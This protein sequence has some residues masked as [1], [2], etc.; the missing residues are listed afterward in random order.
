MTA[1]VPAPPYHS[2]SPLPEPKPV[3][4]P[5]PVP[6]KVVVTAP[7]PPV[8]SILGKVVEVDL[9]NSTGEHRL[10]ISNKSTANV[11][12]EIEKHEQEEEAAAAAATAE[13]KEDDNDDNGM[14]IDTGSEKGVEKVCEPEPNPPDQPITVDV[15]IATDEVLIKEEAKSPVGDT[16]ESESS[17][18]IVPHQPT[19]KMQSSPVKRKK[20]PLPLLSKQRHVRE[21][22]VNATVK[23]AH[24]FASQQNFTSRSSLSGVKREPKD[25]GTGTG[26]LGRRPGKKRKLNVYKSSLVNPPKRVAQDQGPGSTPSVRK[27]SPKQ[28]SATGPHSDSSGQASDKS[29]GSPKRI[30]SPRTSKGSNYSGSSSPTRSPHKPGSGSGS[31]SGIRLRSKSGERQLRSRG[32]LINAFSLPL[33]GT[34]RSSKGSRDGDKSPRR[35]ESTGHKEDPHQHPGSSAAASGSA[36]V[37]STPT[38]SQPGSPAKSSASAESARSLRSRK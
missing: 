7:P 10:T 25:P 28:Q 16:D 29:K 33:H 13:E 18:I 17:I 22:A 1:E 12:E 23:N 8:S 27:V 32:S 20:S 21:S 9:E 30:T 19:P 38:V 4:V 14:E 26:R 3:P 35:R 31:G 36:S 11:Y 2:N 37:S 34:P 24:I 6:P 5:V 15:D